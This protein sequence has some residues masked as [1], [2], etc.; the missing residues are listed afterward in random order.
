MANF[1][2]AYEI[3]KALEGGYANHQSDKGG[4]TFRGIA[5]NFHPKSPIWKYVDEVTAK[6]GYSTTK[7]AP[8]KIRL[9]I[10]E[11]LDKIEAV[12]NTIKP[13]YKKKY[14]DVICLDEINNQEFAE[15][16]FTLCVVSGQKRAVR[17]GQQAC[18]ISADGVYGKQT[19]AAFA[20]ATENEVSLFDKL[21]AERYSNIVKNDSSQKVFLNGWLGRIATRQDMQKAFNNGN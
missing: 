18:N 4:E 9:K 1:N 6:Y 2:R 7:V 11:D 8:K 17:I 13:F 3:L 20:S 14:W 5:R 12:S 21:E 10:T 16:L 15:N 19:K